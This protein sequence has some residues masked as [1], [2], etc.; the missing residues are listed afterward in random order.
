VAVLPRTACGLAETA[1]ITRYL[2][3]SS[4]GQCG[5]CVFGLDAIAGQLERLA[6]GGTCDLT[7]VRRWLGQVTGRGR[8]G[9]RTARRSWWPVHCA[10]SAA[11]LTC[12]PAVGAAPRMPRLCSL[13]GW[14]RNMS[15]GMRLKVDPIACDGRGLC[16]ELLPELITLDDWGYPMLARRDVPSALRAEAAAAVQLCPGSRCGWKALRLEGSG[17]QGRIQP[18]LGDGW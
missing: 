10:S 17:Q 14:D 1:R 12:T 3:R 7:L 16:A 18:Q 5:P 4:A 11:K 6:A 2:A 13:S 15:D 8:A 9:I